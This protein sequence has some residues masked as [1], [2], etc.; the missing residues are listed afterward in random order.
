MKKL[1]KGEFERIFR[2]TEGNPLALKLIKSE[3]VRELEKSG[4]YTPEE[5]T[6]IKYLKSLDKI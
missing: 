4:K 1:E 3:D 2:L 5:L 6:L